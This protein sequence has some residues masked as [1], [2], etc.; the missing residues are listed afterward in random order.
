MKYEYKIMNTQN[1]IILGNT[2]LFQEGVVKL[3]E[4]QNYKHVDNYHKLCKKF[5]ILDST[6][7]KSIPQNFCKL[8]LI[9][10][11]LK[12][13]HTILI[14]GKLNKTE[15]IILKIAKMGKNDIYILNENLEPLPYGGEIL[16][17]G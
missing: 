6:K 5:M 15:E 16:P 2:L 3:L 4:S 11:H 14:A 12:S 10:G 9:F 8:E 1:I 7:E 17:N 13:E